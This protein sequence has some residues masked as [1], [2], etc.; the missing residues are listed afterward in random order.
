[1]FDTVWTAAIALNNTA[2]KLP[3]GQSLLDFHYSNV[4]LSNMIYEE[5]LNVKFFG[6]TVSVHL[7]CFLIPSIKVVITDREMY[8]S[9][10]ME[11]EQETFDCINTDVSL[12]VLVVYVTVYC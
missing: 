7:A 12:N 4:K 9:E 10:E 2:A 8:N 3:S 6:L 5:A 11:T 1:M